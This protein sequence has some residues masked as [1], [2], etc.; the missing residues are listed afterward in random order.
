MALISLITITYNSAATIQETLDSIYSQSFLDLEYIVIDGLSTD[1]TVALI[2]QH[3]VKVHQLVS[4]SDGGLYDALNKGISLAKGDVVGLLHSDDTFYNNTS[5]QKIADEFM[6]G[7]NACYGDLQYLT[8]AGSRKDVR[9]LRHWV[10]GE[11]KK[12]NL[13]Y[14]WMPPHPTFY[15]RRTLYEEFGGYD[16]SFKISGDYHGLLRYLWQHEIVPVYI[17]EVLVKMSVGGA[18]NRSLKNIYNKTL[19]DIRALKSNALPWL[20]GILWKNVRK[21]P[22]YFTRT[23]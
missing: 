18:S 21:I 3:P 16:S 23:S 9:I 8:N 22:Q 7:A 15:M 4:E 11:F 17:P 2:E 12:N 19:E 14:G 5:L 10:A 13:K 6:A 20:P 1:G